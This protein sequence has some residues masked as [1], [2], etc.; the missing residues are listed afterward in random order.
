MRLTMNEYAAALFRPNTPLPKTAP[1]TAPTGGKI[2]LFLPRVV[3]MKLQ[4][5]DA[6]ADADADAQSSARRPA[7]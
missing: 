6:D 3:Q 7:V 2:I 5:A 1:P 4:N